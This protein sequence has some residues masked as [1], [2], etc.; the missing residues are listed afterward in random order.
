MSG[1][2]GTLPLMYGLNYPLNHLRVSTEVFMADLTPP[3]PGY[4]RLGGRMN[5]VGTN[6]DFST[7]LANKKITHLNLGISP[8]T[9]ISW[10][11]LL[12]IL[13]STGSGLLQT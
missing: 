12:Q 5:L 1:T 7:T 11:G 8:L 13:E 2:Q 9:V 6:S 4:Q 3:S 10:C